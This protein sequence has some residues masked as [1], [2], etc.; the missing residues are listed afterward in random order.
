MFSKVWGGLSASFVPSQNHCRQE[1]TISE[2]LPGLLQ[3]NAAFSCGI[4]REQA[5]LRKSKTP[6]KEQ[7][8]FSEPR[9]LQ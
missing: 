4:P 7:V 5:R 1:I 3:E 8:D 2:M 9:L 6:R